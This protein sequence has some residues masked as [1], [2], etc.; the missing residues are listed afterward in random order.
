[1]GDNIHLFNQQDGKYITI[2][3][4]LL[5]IGIFTI[6]PM[7][8]ILGTMEEAKKLKTPIEKTEEYSEME[9]ESYFE[10]MEDTPPP[11]FEYMMMLARKSKADT[12]RR[13]IVENQ[14]NRPQRYEVPND[15]PVQ[16][17]RFRPSTASTMN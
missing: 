13:T 7:Y 14:K 3:L 1:M 16:K 15:T 4:Y 5:Y 11:P 10:P 8:P 12:I 9:M 6:I 2:P 17:G